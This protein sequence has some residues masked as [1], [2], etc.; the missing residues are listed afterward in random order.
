MRFL[1]L[2]YLIGFFFLLS[3]TQR[4]AD[5]SRQ[6]DL[7]ENEDRI[8]SKSPVP[9]ESDKPIATVID[10]QREYTA[11]VN[12]MADGLLDSASFKYDCYGEKSGTVTYFTEKGALRVIVHRYSEYSHFNAVERYYLKDS[13]LFF[14][15][16]NSVTWAFEDGPEGATKDHIREQRT[17]LVQQQPIECLE[18]DF[19]VHSKAENNLHADEVPNKVV[20]CISAEEVLTPFR[21]LVKYHNKPAPECLEK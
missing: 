12:K 19:V 8:V 9:A 5:Q 13:A 6:S 7:Q 18:K 15:Y 21:L 4:P 16:R 20:N 2:S 14:A 17:Y 11:V 3:C 10:I 1:N